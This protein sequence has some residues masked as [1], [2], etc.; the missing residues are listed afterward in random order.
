MFSLLNIPKL[1]NEIKVFTVHLESHNFPVTLINLKA[2]LLCVNKLADN[3][4]LRSKSS[5]LGKSYSC[6]SKL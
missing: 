1:Q 4:G 2:S 5:M 6:V 3:T